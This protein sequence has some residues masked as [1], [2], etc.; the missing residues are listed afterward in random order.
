MMTGE[1]LDY[2]ITLFCQM[3]KKHSNEDKTDNLEKWYKSLEK[4]CHINHAGSSGHLGPF[5]NIYSD[6]AYEM[7]LRSVISR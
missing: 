1:I 6:G 4:V 2:I 5:G 7:F 3:R